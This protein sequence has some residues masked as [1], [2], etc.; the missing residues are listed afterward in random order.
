MDLIVSSYH[1]I[2]VHPLLLSNM[3][4]AIETNGAE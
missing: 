3:M 2:S 4:A 1:N